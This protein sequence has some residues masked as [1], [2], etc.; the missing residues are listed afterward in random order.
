[1]AEESGGHWVDITHGGTI[2]CLSRGN[3]PLATPPDQYAAAG[4]VLASIPKVYAV[5]YAV[6]PA[7]GTP[8][9]PP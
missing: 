4:A 3:R 7:P 1:M 9:L 6:L 2:R 5:W 8:P